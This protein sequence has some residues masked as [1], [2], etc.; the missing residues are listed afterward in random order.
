[1][2]PEEA[3]PVAS[4]GQMSVRLAQLGAAPADARGPS[5][6]NAMRV[7]LNNARSVLFHERREVGALGSPVKRATWRASRYSVLTAETRPASKRWE[8]VIYVLRPRVWPVNSGAIDAGKHT[9]RTMQWNYPQEKWYAT[10]V[11][12]ARKNRAPSA[13]FARSTPNPTQHTNVLD[14]RFIFA[15][16]ARNTRRR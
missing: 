14:V 2:G 7:E 3:R 10:D 8:N 9:A 13:P 4:Q 16:Y 1:M 12:A 11:R 6:L 15:L 5:I